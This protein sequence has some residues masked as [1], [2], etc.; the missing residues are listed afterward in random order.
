MTNSV[1]LEMSAP[2]LSRTTSLEKTTA[3]HWAHCSAAAAG[4]GLGQA[5]PLGWSL[6]R[7]F[8]YHLGNVH[9]AQ[10]SVPLGSTQSGV[11]RWEWQEDTHPKSPYLSRRCA[12]KAKAGCDK[13]SRDNMVKL[14]TGCF[15]YVTFFFNCLYC[16]QSATQYFLRKRLIFIVWGVIK[17]SWS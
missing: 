3:Q 4:W 2:V 8:C 10:G 9:F 6:S 14:S 15:G 1:C 13:T 7:V 17:L 16:F 12:D 5:K 11:T